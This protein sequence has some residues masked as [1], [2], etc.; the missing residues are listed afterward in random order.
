MTIGGR[1]A[2]A[3]FKNP[4]RKLNSP[5]SAPWAIHTA[6]LQLHP[7]A[8]LQID[9]RRSWGVRQIRWAPRFKQLRMLPARTQAIEG[10]GSSAV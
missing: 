7:S 2:A 1:R 3:I 4:L 6:K 10:P 9:H 8:S 5:V